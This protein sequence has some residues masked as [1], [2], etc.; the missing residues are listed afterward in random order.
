MRSDKAIEVPRLL[1][2]K[3]DLSEGTT[4]SLLDVVVRLKGSHDVSDGVLTDQDLGSLRGATLKMGVSKGEWLTWEKIDTANVSLSGKI[5]SGKRAYL[6]T[7]PTLLRA[8]RGDRADILFTPRDVKESP[9]VL[10]EGASILEIGRT[11]EG[12]EIVMALSQAEIETVEKARQTG[13]LNLALRNPSD[14]SKSMRKAR[15]KKYR[16][17]IRPGVEVWAE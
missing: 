12:T 3:R 17:A 16:K 14:E 8:R 9:L 1:A 2:L 7:L 15:P 4:L 11:S 13:K 10:V 6:V 5:P